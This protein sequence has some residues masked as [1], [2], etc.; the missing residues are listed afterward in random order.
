MRYDV[1][2]IG[3]GPAGMS[4]AMTLQKA[5]AKPLV[6]DKATFPRRKTC[7]GLVTGKTYSQ[8]QELFGDS[9]ISSL[10]CYET[11]VIRLFK[12]TEQLT[13]SVTQNPARLVD[14]EVFDNALVSEYRALGGELLEGERDYDID[15]EDS[16]ISFPDGR[17]AE[18]KYIV[19]ADGALGRS[20][21]LIK[22][23]KS[24]MACGIEVYIP[25]E[26]YNTD[27]VDLYFDYLKDGYLWVFPHGSTVCVG[28]ANLFDRSLDYRAVLDGFMDDL[29]IDRAGA[30]Y[31]GAF[32]PY[33]HTA[34]QS[35]LPDNVMLAGD[36]G[37]FADPISGEGLYMALRTGSLAADAMNAPDPKKSYL[38][39][40]KPLIK[41]VS[42]GRT[43]QKLFFSPAVQRKFLSKVRGRNGA[44]SYF[45]D[46]LVDDYKFGYLDLLLMYR[47]YRDS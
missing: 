3:A 38:K 24:R 16:R 40:V 7:A 39:A 6:I 13:R 29:G 27:S 33:G 25:S 12:R 20:H 4:C 5:G 14:R 43:V 2:I 21:K 9:D 10:F 18:Y 35:R 26:K 45:Y 15:L 44:V 36:A 32:L 41:T 34:D 1:V 19:F 31:V 46:N 17:S 47:R 28:A 23:D 11:S 30:R 37:G 22:T 8:I 42:D